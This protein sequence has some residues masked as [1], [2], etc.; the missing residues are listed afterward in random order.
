MEADDYSRRLLPD[1]RC[2]AILRPI[3]VSIDEFNRL[4]VF[5]ADL[6]AG[7]LWEMYDGLF[8]PSIIANERLLT[9]D[10]RNRSSSLSA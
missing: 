3:Y 1:R 5:F 4:V 2:H 9:T 6:Y 8:P 10:V 7:L